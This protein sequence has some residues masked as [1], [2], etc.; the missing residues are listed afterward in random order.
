[1][2]M[3]SPAD[4][5]VIS[6]T[7]ICKSF[8]G[9]RAL[10][11]VDLDLKAGEVHAICGENGAGKSTLMRI[12]AGV[13]RPDQ[14]RYLLDGD[15]TGFSSMAAAARR[16][17]SIVFQEL[18]LFPDLD[19]VQNIFIGREPTKL[20]IVDRRRMEREVAPVIQA[21]GFS[22][23]LAEPVGNLRIADQQL[24]EIAKAVAAKSR[25]LILDEPNSA[26]N[27]KESERLFSVVDDL[28]RQG[29]GILYISHRLSEVLRISDRVTTLRNGRN[30]ATHAARDLS[31]AD[32]VADMLGDKAKNTPI[33]AKRK[34]RTG[35]SAEPARELRFENVSSDG[36]L[37]NCSFSASP[38]ETLGL[39][40]LEGSG[41]DEI[42]DL[43]FGRRKLVA[44]KIA[45]PQ[46]SSAPKSP[47][48]AARAGVAL[49][50][51][52]RR[53]E[54]LALNQSILDNMNVV[55]SGSLAKLGA[56]PRNSDM[57][58]TAEEQARSLNLKFGKMGDPAGS[59]SGGNQQKIV[60]G[61]WLATNPGVILLDDPARGVDIGARDEIFSVISRLS[62][63]ERITLY[64]S[65][66]LSEYHHV[67]DRV[68][69]LHEGRVSGEIDGRDAQEHNL[70][71]AINV[72]GSDGLDEIRPSPGG[73]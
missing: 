29:V 4:D 25:V 47:A 56:F 41:C 61:K 6:L 10:S 26:L 49:I 62:E 7:G 37:R 67:C 36:V 63:E 64:Y 58:A 54:G 16:G 53:T 69:L 59:L 52:D 28:R 65:T 51:A 31:I 34:R 13:E 57:V 66:E 8:G 1:M 2:A 20:G 18:S 35:V 42:L 27:S 50:P 45:V 38:G 71:E 19:A 70:L 21:L 15:A 68:L 5:L 48:E 17:V 40:G 9:V 3:N 60:I 73:N 23:S 44:G 55:V 33:R 22:F 43:I 12:I 30:V 32:I 39:A 11:G 14:G 46:M 24:I 72:R